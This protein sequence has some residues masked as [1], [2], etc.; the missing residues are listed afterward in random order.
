[1][2]IEIKFDSCLPWSV[3]SPNQVRRSGDLSVIWKESREYPSFS[4][5]DQ[6]ISTTYYL[7][8]AKSVSSLAARLFSRCK[9]DWLN[10]FPNFQGDYTHVLPINSLPRRDRQKRREEIGSRSRIPSKRALSILYSPIPRTK[11]EGSP[12]RRQFDHLTI[13]SSK[14]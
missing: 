8:F 14:G 12:I 5:A 6:E 4:R 3:D 10:L 11:R 13:A 7:S 2:L 9:I 1:M